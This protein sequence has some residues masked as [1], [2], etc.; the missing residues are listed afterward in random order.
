MKISKLLKAM[1]F[2]FS[3]FNLG[4]V[5]DGSGDGGAAAAAAEAEKAA[6]DAAALAAAEAEA[7]KNKPTDQEAKLLKEVMQKKDALKKSE[8]S[9]A[10]A[11]ALLK[12]FDG[13]DPVAVK[14][15]LD[16][17]KKTEETQLEAKGEW[18]RL[19]VR[20]A[21]EH[22]TKTKT[23]EEQIASLTGQ[24]NEKSGVINELSVGTQFGQSSFIADELILTPAK[25]RVVYG[26]HFE[27]LDGKVVA[28]DKPRSAANRTALVDQYGNHVGFDE[29]LRKIVD[30]DPDK[31]HLLKSKAKPG[32]NSGS[33]GTVKVPTGTVGID[34]V[35][36]IGAGLAGLNLFKSTSM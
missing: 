5:E 19:K 3:M 13:I 7:N 23:L 18:D 30:A 25:A 29:A 9:L 21:E 24:L 2:A 15:L 17:Q 14:A 4:I 32:A 12:Q 31:D 35:S 28:Y 1:L 33:K 34:S 6:A 11:Q 8:D 16:Q 20:M 22:T 36:K 27:L 10:A 26:D